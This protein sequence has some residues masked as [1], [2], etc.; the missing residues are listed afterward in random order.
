VFFR[1]GQNLLIEIYE[2]PSDERRADERELMFTHSGDLLE[3]S[4]SF[5]ATFDQLFADRETDEFEFNWRQPFPLAEYNTFK[6]AIE[7]LSDG[8]SALR[9]KPE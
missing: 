1:D 9:G 3:T 2:Y 5:F 8:V 4:R 7:P 6:A